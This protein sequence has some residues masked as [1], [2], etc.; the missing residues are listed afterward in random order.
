MLPTY[1]LKVNMREGWQILSDIGHR[2]GVTFENQNKAYNPA[3]PWTRTFSHKKAFCDFVFNF[4]ACCE[5]YYNRTGKCPCWCEWVAEFRAIGKSDELFYALPEDQEAET[6][7]YLT[8][9]KADKMTADE[10]A[11]L[12]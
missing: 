11:V 2:F 7:N 1:A 9:A 10:L 8:T 4:D 5:E 3:H 6:I 12:K